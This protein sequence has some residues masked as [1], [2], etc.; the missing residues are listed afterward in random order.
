MMLIEASW[1]S[2][3]DAAVT[4]RTLLTG[5]R[6][7]AVGLGWGAPR[8]TSCTS[9]RSVIVSTVSGV[10]CYRGVRPGWPFCAG[11]VGGNARA[12]RPVGWGRSII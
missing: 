7:C 4:K 9:E 12:A 8:R 5:P 3:S 1:P 6:P 10:G 11:L 2:N